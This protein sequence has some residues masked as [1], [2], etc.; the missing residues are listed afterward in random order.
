MVKGALFRYARKTV[1]T[2]V[3]KIDIRKFALDFMQSEEGQELQK[4][5]LFSSM[6]SR[7]FEK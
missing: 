7:C 5:S 4:S 1:D 6:R 2:R 3:E